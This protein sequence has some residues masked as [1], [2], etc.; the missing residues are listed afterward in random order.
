MPHSFSDG[1]LL[2]QSI[3]R[4]WG[5]I[6][7]DL[8]F[9]WWRHPA[10]V[11]ILMYA[12]GS[13]HF[14]GG[15]FL[16]LQYVYTLLKTR[17]YSYVDFSLDFAHRTGGDP[18]ATVAGAK[19]LTDPALD[20]MNKYDEIWFFGYDSTPNLTPP[21]VTLLTQ[22]MAAP[23]FGGVL[24]TGD[25]DNLGKGIAGQIPRAGVMR[26]YPAPTSATPVWNNTVEEGPDPGATYDH[27]DQ[28]D[29]RPQTIRYRRYA[30]ASPFV[31]ARRYRPH[32]VLC[33]PDGPIDVLPDHQHEGEALAPAPAPGDLSWPTKAGH[34]E[35]PQVIAWGKIKDPGADKH[36]QEIGVISAYNG[37]NVDVGRILADSTWHHWFDINLTGIATSPSPYAGFDETPA[38][39]AAL[40]KID[41][42]FL[43]CGVWLAPPARQTEMKHAAWW[44]ILWSDRMVEL[45][46]QASLAR[47]GEEAINV[48]G[49]RAA[50]CTVSEFILDWP[51]FK[52]KI[53]QWEWPMLFERFQLIDLPFEKYVAGGI[54]KHLLQEVG[55]L[56]P[57][58]SFPDKAIQD[59]ILQK[60]MRAGV[61]EG[62]S[63]LTKQLRQEAALVAKLT[64]SGFRA[65]AVDGRVRRMVEEVVTA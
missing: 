52:E 45:S 53:P 54:L 56:N 46:P 64:E 58:L 34:Q 51:I 49:L 14:N 62:M 38:G 10:K 32:P 11:R 28:S 37:H 6:D 50:R 16:G 23:K 4:R 15:S 9:P 33:G 7:W 43:N 40:K 31:L 35:S 30:V 47:L 61:E 48:L 24:V 2:Q 18:T 59:D 21:E 13:V 1:Q 25:H 36:G 65:E 19:L 60:V 63:T 27:E 20:I 42:Y 29:D 39:Q 26:Q 44:S 17:A 55:P 8:H 57:K 5:V 3:R 12:D 22:F 41:A